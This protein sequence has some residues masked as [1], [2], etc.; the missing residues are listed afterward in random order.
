MIYQVHPAVRTPSIQM[1][2]LNIKIQNQKLRKLTVTTILFFWQNSTSSSFWQNGLISIW[3]T[4]GL[5]L[6]FSKTWFNWSI[7]KLL[8]PMLFNFLSATS[9]SM[10]LKEKKRL[11]SFWKIIK[12]KSPNTKP[13]MLQYNRHQNIKKHHFHRQDIDHQYL[14]IIWKFKT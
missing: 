12:T 4:T 5:M 14:P 8:T 11:P 13:Y 3:L 2:S 7:L 6:H 1:D 9:C 10:V